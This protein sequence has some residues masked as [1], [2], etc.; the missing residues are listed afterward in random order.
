MFRIVFALFASTACF[1]Q[2]RPAPK[3]QPPPP[4]HARP[5]KPA[6]Q[7]SNTV[8]QTNSDAEIER[9]FRERLK[10][11]KM[12]S[13]GFNIRVQGGVA[14]LEGSTEVVQHKGAATRMAKA[15]GARAVVN[16]IRVSDAARAKS[17]E[18]LE[19]GR[20]RE[21]RTRSEDRGRR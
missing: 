10:R 11:S 5:A 2:V 12:A 17:A 16:R 8:A 7:A 19:Q 1:A 9:D 20:R 4:A 6:S 13:S 14:T 3:T 15:A 21:Q 18:N